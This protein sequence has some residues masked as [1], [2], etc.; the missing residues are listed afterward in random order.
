MEN[1]PQF[2]TNVLNISFSGA[3]TGDMHLKNKYKVKI[4]EGYIVVSPLMKSMTKKSF[5]CAFF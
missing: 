4:H 1:K 5:F 3:K 2:F